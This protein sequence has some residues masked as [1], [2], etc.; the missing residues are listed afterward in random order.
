[1]S[2][3]PVEKRAHGVDDNN[4]EY[5]CPPVKAKRQDEEH[6]SH[7]F[8]I[9]DHLVKNVLPERCH[10][11]KVAAYYKGQLDDPEATIKECRSFLAGWVLDMWRKRTLWKHDKYISFFKMSSKSKPFLTLLIG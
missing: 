3:L 8:F 2:S 5:E 7:P 1:M 10:N 6:P 4:A 11:E 9:L